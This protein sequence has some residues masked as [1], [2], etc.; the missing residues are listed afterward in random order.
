M[1]AIDME[2]LEA[3]AEVKAA[4]AARARKQQSS[5]LLSSR[6]QEVSSIDREIARRDAST[7]TEF[8]LSVSR[9]ASETEGMLPIKDLEEGTHDAEMWSSRAW[10]LPPHIPV[11]SQHPREACQSLRLYAFCCVI[12]SFLTVM[13]LIHGVTQH[14]DPRPEALLTT[15]WSSTETPTR[16]QH[17][18]TRLQPRLRT[19]WNTYLSTEI[20]TRT[21]HGHTRLHAQLRTQ[22][23]TCPCS[24]DQTAQLRPTKHVLTWKRPRRGREN[25]SHRASKRARSG[26][27]QMS[28]AAS[29]MRNEIGSPH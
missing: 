27:H 25:S 22:W 15:K 16:T 21:Q 29:K 20:L 7:D 9:Y 3:I 19:K 13:L 1:S 2:V 10:T 5:S 11:H 18:D 23:S 8:L 4:Y 24:G 28:G 6:D 12:V 14:R 17:R 26:R